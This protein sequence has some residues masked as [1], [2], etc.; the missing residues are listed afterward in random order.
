MS[1]VY[2]FFATQC[3]SLYSPFYFSVCNDEAN[4][5]TQNFSAAEQ[6]LALVQSCIIAR[7][8]A[9][10]TLRNISFYKKKQVKEM[11]FVFF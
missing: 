9:G 11:C 10:T 4:M 8:S 1:L 6:P 5:C 7:R 2:Y 3:I